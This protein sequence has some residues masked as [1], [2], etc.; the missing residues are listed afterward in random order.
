MLPSASSL[1]VAMLSLAL[2][3]HCKVLSGAL[4]LLRLA[5]GAGAELQCVPGRLFVRLRT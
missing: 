3:K 4:T 1:A 5:V 2:L